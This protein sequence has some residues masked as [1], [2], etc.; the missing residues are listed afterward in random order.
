M[1]DWSGI[2][3]ELKELM[4]CFR[5]CAVANI[6]DNLERAKGARGLRPF[7]RQGT[8]AG[9]ALTVRTSAGDNAWIYRAFEILQPGDVLVIDGGGYPDRALI[10]E[11]MSK[12]AE[13]KGA[14]GMVLDGAI[15]DVDAIGAEDFPVFARAVSHL[16]PY[17]NGPGALNEPVSIGGMVVTPGDIIVGDADGLVAFGPESA[18]D[19]L[20]ATQAQQRKEEEILSSIADGSYAGAYG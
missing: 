10:G 18:K 11:I 14:V 2:E 1:T 9:R 8:M 12:I 5:G 19:L 13:A 7:H 15:R 6:S 20:L 17:K 3:N 16:G 4:A